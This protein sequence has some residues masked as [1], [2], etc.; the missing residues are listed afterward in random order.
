MTS[1]R[2][3]VSSYRGTVAAT[4]NLF[5]QWLETYQPIINTFPQANGAFDGKLFET[6][7]T[8]VEEV[9]NKPE[10]LVWS[11]IEGDEE[12]YITPG[13]WRVNRL[14]YFICAVPWTEPRPEDIVIGEAA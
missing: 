6:W 13:F 1:K 8:E 3:L 2:F 7:G 10:N 12:T 4:T 14:G 5:D 11:L 9:R